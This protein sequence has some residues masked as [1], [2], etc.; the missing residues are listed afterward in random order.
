M[1]QIKRIGII[2]G[3]GLGQALASQTKGQA[4]HVDTP[5]G[6]PSAPIIKTQLEGVPIAFLA[7][8]GEGHM[9]NPSAVP[10]R[11]NIYALKMMGVTHIIASGATGSL[12]EEMAPKHLVVADQVIDK[13]FKRQ[14]T[15]FETLAVHVDFA[16]PFCET[17]RTLLIDAGKGIDTTVHSS[18]TYVCMEGPQFSTRAESLLHKS[19]GAQLIGMT[20]MPEA[21]LAREAEIPYAL[22]A[23]PTDYD[24][25]R[26]HEGD[27]DKHSLMTEIIG[28]LNGATDNAIN[29]IT[30][31][32]KKAGEIDLLNTPNEHHQALEMG[33][34][35][36]KSKITPAQ[37]QKLGIIISKYL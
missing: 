16:Y 11:A 7:R 24:C 27:V 25:W 10:Y 18:G 12:V 15:F 14:S 32:V 34:W 1:G 6:N 13:T 3:S 28:N 2:G 33:I 22:L 8:H 35:S 20:V 9:F 4:H 36:D 19:W 17:L 37:K 29:L 21:R 26:P 30:K 5:F 31:A 23:L